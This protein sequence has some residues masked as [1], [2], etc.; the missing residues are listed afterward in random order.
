MTLKALHEP[1]GVVVPRVDS[2]D[3]ISSLVRTRI[4]RTFAVRSGSCIQRSTED[5]LISPFMEV[6][7]CKCVPEGAP[8]LRRRPSP[9]P[10]SLRTPLWRQ[11]PTAPPDYKYSWADST[12]QVSALSLRSW[13]FC[14]R[15]PKIH[16][17]NQDVNSFDV[18]CYHFLNGKQS[19]ARFYTCY[20]IIGTILGE[21][22]YVIAKVWT[23]FASCIIYL[24]ITTFARSILPKNF[25]AVGRYVYNKL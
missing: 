11:R 12:P 21:K 2:T 13:Y 8:S 20:I 4:L 14:I 18:R 24:P 17:M 6:R 7:I 23:K 3:S 10:R 5:N 15:K 25:A 1:S 19:S 16:C 22:V 9:S